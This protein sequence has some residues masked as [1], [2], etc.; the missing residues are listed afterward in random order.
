MRARLANR[1]GTARTYSACGRPLHRLEGGIDISGLAYFER[2]EFDAVGACFP[3]LAYVE[4]GVGIARI[5]QDR[6][7][8]QAGTSSCKSPSFLPAVSGA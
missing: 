7:P 4:R 2:G 8:V 3:N 6:Q 5:G 1:S